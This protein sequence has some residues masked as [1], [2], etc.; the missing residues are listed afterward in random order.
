MSQAR[1]GAFHF[2]RFRGIDVYVHWMWFLVAAY[3][4]Q[5][6]REAYT[7]LAWNAG[8]YLALF[9]IVLMHEF[10]HA[11]ACRQTGGTVGDILLWP[12]G[13]VARVSPPQRPGAMLWS[14]AAGPLVNVALL[15]VF[16]LLARFAFHAD[17][18]HT[19]PNAYHFLYT[20]QYINIVLLIF[21]LLPIYPLDGGQILR[22]ILWY[23]TGRA[24][25]LRIAAGLGF[26]GVAFLVVLAFYLRSIWMGLIAA[27]AFMNCKSGW[28]QATR[29]KELDAIPRRTGF[30]CPQCKESPLCGDFWACPECQ[31]HFDTFATGGRCPNCLVQNTTTTC[32]NCGT[33]SPIE[34]WKEQ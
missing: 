26:L 23:F 22:S 21:N 15:P 11:F 10:G 24:K 28:Q 17:W 25:S 16:F 29:L 9:G 31:T 8:E 19:Q 14:I 13:G 20:L 1:Q 18:G 4:M 33:P 6:R 12:L 7:S 5:T 30:S 3:E 32:P 27:F 34:D 2:F